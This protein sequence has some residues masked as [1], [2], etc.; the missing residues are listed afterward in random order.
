MSNVKKSLNASLYAL[1]HL[2]KRNMKI[3][4]IDRVRVFFAL[5]APLIVLLLYVLFLGDIQVN[6][7]MYS[8]PQGITVSENAVHAYVDTWMLAGVLS[9]ACISVSLSANTVMVEDKTKGILNDFLS[10]PVKRWVITASYFLYNFFTT[11]IILGVTFGI[12]LIYLVVSGGWYLTVT[13]VLLTITTIILS[14]ISATLVTVFICGF[15]RSEAALS[16]FIGILSSVLGF[17]IGAY[18]PMSIMPKA[19]QYISSLIPGSHSAGLF[20][21][22]LMTGAMENLSK[23]MPAGVMSALEETFAMKISFFGTQIGTDIMYIYLAG[24]IVIFAILGLVFNFNPKMKIK[25][26]LKKIK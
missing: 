23:D 6:S 2:T 4:L 9:I 26:K 19:F 20:R 3:F 1:M 14:S 7:V 18:M 16:G 15:F 11:I 10:S 13:D 21:N 12:C 24:S 22:Y 5:L 25:L 8:I 17:L